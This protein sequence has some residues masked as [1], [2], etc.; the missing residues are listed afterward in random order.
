[1]RPAQVSLHTTPFYLPSLPYPFCPFPFPFLPLSFPR[2]P[3]PPS[4]PLSSPLLKVIPILRLRGLGELWGALKLP[5]RVRSEP[6]RQT[7]SGA[8]SAFYRASCDDLTTGKTNLLGSL[9]YHCVT[10][11]LL[12]P[13]AVRTPYPPSYATGSMA[14]DSEVSTLSVLQSSVA[15][16]HQSCC[17]YAMLSRFGMWTYVVLTVRV[18]SD[19]SIHMHWVERIRLRFSFFLCVFLCIFLT[20][21]SLFIIGLVILYY[22]VASTSTIDCL[23]K[24]RH[25]CYVSSG[26]LNSTHQWH[27]NHFA[28][29]SWAACFRDLTSEVVQRVVLA[30]AYNVAVVTISNSKTNKSWADVSVVNRNQRQMPCFYY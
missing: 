17:I 23:E 13:G 14:Y 27:S 9:G 5:Q 16:W 8:F 12:S 4:P 1:M 21:A 29:P 30:A 19:Q 3:I 22:L 2:Y 18:L 15:L 10:P 6:G 28:G 11:P 20:K 25:V 7:L 24:L 26:T